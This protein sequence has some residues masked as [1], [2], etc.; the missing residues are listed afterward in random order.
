MFDELEKFGIIDEVI[1]PV[2]ERFLCEPEKLYLRPDLIYRFIVDE[3]C[4]RCVELANHYR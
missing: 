4:S 3:N 2:H 1:E